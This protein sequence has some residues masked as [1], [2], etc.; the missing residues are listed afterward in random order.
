MKGEHTIRFDQPPFTDSGLFAITGPT[1]SGKTTILDAITVALYGKV[2]RHDKNVEE[3]MSRN[4]S[5][6]YSEVE[7]EVQGRQYRAKWSKKRSFKKATGTL[8]GDK[9]E[10]YELN[11]ALQAETALGGHTATLIKTAIVEVCGLDYD[12][13]LRSVILSQGDFTR[14]LKATDSERSELLEKITGTGIYSEISRYVYT[15]KKKEQSALETC[16]AQLNGTTVLPEEKKVELNLQLADQSALELDLKRVQTVLNEKI[17]WLQ[18]LDKIE[19]REKKIVYDLAEELGVEELNKEDFMR[20]RQHIQASAFQTELAVLQTKKEHADKLR[21]DADKLAEKLPL[22][23]SQAEIAKQALDKAILNTRNAE[24]AYRLAEPILDQTSQL[25]TRIA[26]LKEVTEKEQQQLLAA[27]QQLQVQLEKQQRT[28]VSEQALAQELNELESW[29]QLNL[30]DK[31]LEKQLPL[32]SRAME[33]LQGL[34]QDLLVSGAEQEKVL[35]LEAGQKTAGAE[36]TSKIQAFEKAAADEN[37]KLNAHTSKQH[38]LL[39]Q[40]S[41]GELNDQAKSLP[42]LIRNCE[43]ANRLSVGYLK[44][45]ETGETM[46]RLIAGQQESIKHHSHENLSL[47]SE[48]EA[49]QGHLNDLNAKLGAEQRIQSYE[50]A[51]GALQPDQPCFLCGS[52]K[53][54]FIEGAYHS[55]LNETELKI[56]IQERSLAELLKKIEVNSTLLTSQEVMMQLKKKDIQ[57][58]EIQKLEIQEQFRN[59]NLCLPKPL[60]IEKQET[61][62][63]VLESKKLKHS[64]VQLALTELDLISR[65]INKSELDIASLKGE[66][67]AA[68]ERSVS[69]LERIQEAGKKFMEYGQLIISTRAKQHKLLHELSELLRPYKIDFNHEKIKEIQDALTDRAARYAWSFSKVQELKHELTRLGADLQ[70]LVSTLKEK[71]S[72]LEKSENE[73]KSGIAKLADLYT[74]RKELLGDKDPAHERNVYQHKIKS[75]REL[76]DAASKD[77][78]LRQGEAELA[79]ATLN[80]LSEQ[81]QA[82]HAQLDQ[83]HTQL[84][85]K[86]LLK[87]I[88]SV[89]HLQQQ[90]LSIE[91]AEKLI[92]LENELKE[93]IAALKQ[94][95][96]KIKAESE[97]ENQKQ[98]TPE[99]DAQLKVQMETNQQQLAELY[100]QTGKVKQILN[101]DANTRSRFSALA[102]EIESQQKQYLKWEKLDKLIGSADGKSFSRFAQGLTLARLTELANLHLSRLSDRYQILKSSEDDLE[103]LIVDAYQADAIRPMTTL[104]GGE[105]FLVSLAL[106]FGLSDLASKKVQ[107]DTLFIDEGFGSLDADTLDTAISALENL[108]SRGKM[109]GIISHV[110]ALK[111]RIST[112]IQLSKQSGGISKIF[113]EN[114]MNKSAAV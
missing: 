37:Q 65:D 85:G 13:F 100:E 32:V 49:L 38:A 42:G 47:V 89:K 56:G 81:H 93:S 63:R 77:L 50:E 12:Q 90:L 96:K 69:I 51:R 23:L 66:I 78:H 19:E 108:Q 112:Q 99:T 83:L 46:N 60:D 15:R 9:M 79:Q 6:S 26:Y 64:E 44:L 36:N 102:L 76:N 72:E 95:L 14:F 54:P 107:I 97:A 101:E 43:E 80:Q 34:S 33:D 74:G 62:S 105:S 25:D 98:L 67:M 11:A 92:K 7:F 27:D 57:D 88:P 71:S 16:K 2:H 58:L 109:I 1:G 22:Y 61:I 94:E 68:N 28:I 103:L 4:T 75:G 106:A 21:R 59:V 104:S 17:Q 73:L 40:N 41:A 91:E 31:D 111:E 24:D 113:I 35:Q 87:N 70:N 20:L 5:E 55:A 82:Q 45:L 114:Y 39:Q 110:E 53:H 29:M 10:F 3:M 48:K 18:N 84:I 30:A 52:L 86:L 8:S